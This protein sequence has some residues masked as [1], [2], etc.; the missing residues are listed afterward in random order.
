M[1][2]SE[3]FGVRQEKLTATRYIHQ[4][5]TSRVEMHVELHSL[6][7]ESG[8]SVNSLVHQAPR[9]LPPVPPVLQLLASTL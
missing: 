1:C 9:R 6:V 5:L 3:S 7:N 2:C 4:D 8:W